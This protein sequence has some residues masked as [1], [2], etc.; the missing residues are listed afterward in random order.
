[1]V[2]IP[3]ALRA[4]A[5]LVPIPAIATMGVF[6]VSGFMDSATDEPATIANYSVRN[7]DR[8]PSCAYYIAQKARLPLVILR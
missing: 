5:G 7:S 3:L 1:M 8:F 6:R 2:M 4:S